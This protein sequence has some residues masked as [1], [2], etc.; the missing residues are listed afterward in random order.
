M[1]FRDTS[2]GTEDRLF[3][4]ERDMAQLPVLLQEVRAKLTRYQEALEQIVSTS[5]EVNTVA[6]AKRALSC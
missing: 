6:I 2:L 4:A 1:N 3:A 5:K